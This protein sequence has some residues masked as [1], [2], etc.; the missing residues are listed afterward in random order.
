[1]QQQTDYRKPGEKE[2]E[3]LLV[4]LTKT[5]KTRLKMLAES[6]GLKSL[7]NY[8]R[9]QLLNPSIESKLNQILQLI[10]N[11]SQEYKNGK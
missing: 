6:S 5:Q 1:M 7:S 8:V 4:R 3:I 9:I 10:E 2:N 11:K